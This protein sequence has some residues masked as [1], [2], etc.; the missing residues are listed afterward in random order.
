[1]SNFTSNT[2]PY[3]LELVTNTH[4][5]NALS[6]SC[7]QL[8]T[9]TFKPFHKPSVSIVCKRIPQTHCKMDRVVHF[10]EERCDRCTLF[11]LKAHVKVKELIN[12]VNKCKQTSNNGRGSGR[13]CKR[14]LFFSGVWGKHKAHSSEIKRRTD[15][16]KHLQPSP[17]STFNQQCDSLGRC[18]SMQKKK[19]RMNRIKWGKL[20]QKT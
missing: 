15:A 6:R 19:A 3:L 2:S 16:A 4:A 1:M 14:D 5:N 10:R 8:L 7:I 9:T 13:Q 12:G 18:G 11:F 20:K 17:D